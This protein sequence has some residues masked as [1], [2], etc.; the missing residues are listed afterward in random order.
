M[1]G[2]HGK[3]LV[4]LLSNP[5]LPKSDIGLVDSAIK[6]YEGWVERV[7]DL[8]ARL[9]ES[10]LANDSFIRDMVWE[11]NQYKKLIDMGLIYDSEHNF[12][13]RNKGQLKVCSTIM[14][15]FLERFI[16][17][18]FPELVDDLEMGSM[19]CVSSMQFSV[20]EDSPESITTLD[21]LISLCMVCS[22]A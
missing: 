4:A 7:D 14:E 12:L 9:K 21:G 5:R 20:F 15:E 13:Y 19:R 11:V 2:R 8:T 16:P 10:E 3:A 18:L 17:P 22:W 1:I 6:W